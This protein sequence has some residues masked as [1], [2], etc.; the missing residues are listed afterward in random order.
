[1]AHFSKRGQGP[2]P[3]RRPSQGAGAPAISASRPEG[4]ERREEL[5]LCGLGAVRARFARDPGSIQRLF[6]DLA[7]SKQIG[8]IC[9]VLAQGKKVYRCVEPAELEKIAGSIHHGGIVA[10]VSPPALRV[11]TSADVK[12]WAR[13][14]EPLLVLDRVG[15]AHNLGAIAR[16]A[17]FFGLP[18][19]VIPDDP[20]AARPSEAS[21]RV[22]EGGLEYVEV[23]QTKDLLAFVRD[24]TAAGYEVVGAAT[25]G[26]RPDAPRPAERKPFALVLGNEE[27][28]IAP[29]VLAACTRLVTIPGHGKVESLNVSVAAAVLMWE[30]AARR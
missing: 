21:H 8:A 24:L 5:K 2:R 28:G 14:G 16:T 22:A 29:A 11:T 13:R 7:T 12:D 20:A 15:N 6:F 26:G 3:H 17:A 4:P 27:H 19:I 9:K 23:W 30:L 25:R 18:R 1:M 10:I